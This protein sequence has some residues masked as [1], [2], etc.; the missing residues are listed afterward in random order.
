MMILLCNRIPGRSRHA[1]LDVSME[2]PVRAA[3]KIGQWK[4]DTAPEL[5][6]VNIM[7]SGSMLRVCMGFYRLG[8]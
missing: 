7:D 2:A 3:S 6:T 8:C 4:P 1:L 5:Y